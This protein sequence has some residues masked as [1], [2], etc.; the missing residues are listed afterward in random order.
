MKYFHDFRRAV[1]LR[2]KAPALRQ[3]AGI[4]LTRP[5]GDQDPNGR[6]AVPNGSSKLET[7]SIPPR[8]FDTLGKDR[9]DAH[10]RD[11]ALLV[12]RQDPPPGFSTDEAVATIRNVLD[13]GRRHGPRRLGRLAPRLGPFRGRR[14]GLFLTGVRHSEASA[15]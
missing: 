1:G 12:A 3:I 5:E 4:K 11:R 8:Y 6:P 7:H 15:P 2:Q 9:A 10:A 13:T 14:L